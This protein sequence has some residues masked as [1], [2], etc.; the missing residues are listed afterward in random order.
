MSFF[1]A[2]FGLLLH[3]LIWGAGLALLF[4]PRPWAR[5]W[6]LFAAPAGLALQSAVVWWGALTHLAGTD[7]YAWLCEVIPV[8]SL[9][10]GLRSR[11]WLT[12]I[13][14]RADLGRVG[15]VW[16][17]MVV[18][19]NALLIPMTTASKVLTTSSLGSC[20]AAD[21]AAGARVFQEFASNDR[22]GFIGL[23]EVVRVGSADNFFDFW[24]RLNH[25]TPSAL[26]AFND[27]IFGLAPHESI[28][29]MTAVFVSLTLPMVFWL[30]RAGLR[31]GPAAAVAVALVYGVSPVLWYAVYHVAMAQLLAALA[32]AL[33]TW[34]G[35]ALWKSG[36]GWRRGWRLAGL[37]VVAY[38]LLLGA[39]NFILVVALV[40]AAAY[41]GG[42]TLVRQSWA[43]LGRWCVLMA[44]PLVLAGIIFSGRVS[45]LVERFQLFQQYDFGWKIPAMTPEGWLGMVA[46]ERLHGYA[47]W[48]RW[49]LG[50]AMVL[51]LGLSLMRSIMRRDRTVFAVVCFTVPILMGYGFLQL[52]GAKLG[53]NASYD[54]YKLL[55]VFYPGILGAMCY[56]LSLWRAKSV[57]LKGT[58]VALL[59]TVLAFNFFA[60]WRFSKRMQSPPLMV[61]RWLVQLQ[62]V[63]RM[64]RFSSFNMLANDGWSRL[65][66][67]AFL[68]RRHQYF[69]VH[70][71]EGR[72]NTELKGDWDLL[73]GVI[74]IRLPEDGDAV[75]DYIDLSRPGPGAASK[76][77][78]SPGPG[79]QSGP[80][81]FSLVNTKSDYFIRARMDEGWYDAE[82]IPRMGTR[83]RWTR[84]DAKIRIENPHAYP[85]KV[86]FRFNAR[87]TVERDLQIWIGDRRLRTAKIGK[88]LK[89]VSVASIEI[90]PGETLVELRSNLPALSPGG[91]DGRLLGFAA[92]G[93]EL[94]V[95]PNEEVLEP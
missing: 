29:V 5:F 44:S 67:N 87:G 37:L 9:V 52:R 73:C 19:L 76:R 25:F 43:Q 4:T 32:V 11:G 89:V 93:I 68:L 50:G 95:R 81:P 59:A 24:T 80:L 60:A 53:T 90:P 55:A 71:Y 40:P 30:A 56:W 6:P 74:S 18:T 27:S 36:A 45:G 91:G 41:A 63:E 39:Y 70:T 23:T 75:P 26:V 10:A 78:P 35:L 64:E 58:V 1:L 7:S 13:Q 33:L 17:M 12:L 92:Y 28:S 8:L 72:L 65:W 83:W 21:Y 20:D 46:D 3:I 38:W 15:A 42:Q 77:K 62:G 31:L 16:L 61:D 82:Q 49:V 85:L 69:A 94:N 57:V 47:N 79:P 34:C 84:G 2:G 54:A 66:A 48:L 86:A 51:V 14:L 22:S 88:E